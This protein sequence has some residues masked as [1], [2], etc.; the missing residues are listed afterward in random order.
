MALMLRLCL[1]VVALL[2]A[3]SQDIIAL[4]LPPDYHGHVDQLFPIIAFSVLCANLTSFVYGNMVQAHKRPW[5]LVIPNALGSVATI[6]LS[7]LLIPPMAELGAAS[8]LAGGSLVGLIT[9]IVISERLTPV[10]VPWRDV[11]I[12]MLIAVCTGVGASLA[13]AGLGDV[14]A[15]FKLGAGGCAGGLVFLGLNS[16]FHPEATMQLAG[17]LRA[18]LGMA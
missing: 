6:A 12:S 7:L 13:S 11:G 5:L 18:R 3:L 9:C 16:L 2:V 4:V 14:A 15:I 10:P 8:A 17:K 1:P